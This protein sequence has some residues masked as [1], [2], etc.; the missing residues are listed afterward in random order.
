MSGDIPFRDEFFGTVRCFDILLW[1]VMRLLPDAGSV[2]I[3][4]YIGFALTVSGIG[5]LFLSIRR[6]IDPVVLSAAFSAV[7]YTDVFHRWTPGYQSMST[8]LMSICAG[9]WIRGTLAE[10]R[11]FM[12]MWGAFSGLFFFSLLSAIFLILRLSFSRCY[13]FFFC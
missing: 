1:P 7:I 6:K 12:R 13:I 11:P 4:R 2:L 9:C 10:T 5:F 3:F 8:A